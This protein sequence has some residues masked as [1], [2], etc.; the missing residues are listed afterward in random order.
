MKPRTVRKP[1]SNASQ[2]FRSRNAIPDCG[3]TWPDDTRRAP[4][5][6]GWVASRLAGRM[7]WSS[8][9]RSAARTGA[10]RRSPS[11]RSRMAPEADQLPAR[12]EV[13][14]LVG[15]ALGPGH[16]REAGEQAGAHRLGADIG[17]GPT[18][19]VGVERRLALLRAT[20]LVAADRAAVVPGRRPCPSGDPRL[21]VDRPGDLVDDERPAA[22][23]AAGREQVADRDLETRCAARRGGHPLER[24]VEVADVG[25]PEDDLGEHP[26]ERVR[27]DRDR[28]ALPVDGRPRDP[29]ATAEQVGDDIAGSRV[30]FDPR[31]HHRGRRRGRDPVED[32]K[33]EARPGIEGST[34]GH[35]ADA[36]RRAIRLADARPADRTGDRSG[37]ARSIRPSSRR[38]DRCRPSSPTCWRSPTT[39]SSAAGAG[40]RPTSTSST[41]ATAS[42]A[43]T[44][45]WNRRSRRSPTGRGAGGSGAAGRTGD[46][47]TRRRRRSRAGSCRARWP[48]C[49]PPTGTPTRAVA[50]G[51]CGRRSATSSPASARTAGSTRGS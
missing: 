2:G 11:I 25:R 13:E 10:A 31:G 34:S 40:C 12:V 33:R 45:R 7:A 41:S 38:E 28:Q 14:Q 22:G 35:Q 8:A 19:V 43:S 44:S 5:R 4:V 1:S 51:R 20:A 17:R 15:Q 16:D 30:L 21:V 49:P 24:G 26:R 9:R 23:R 48:A 29:A 32:R 47:G 3:R 37:G 36:S 27:L 6:P 42:I 46:P 39:R 50:S 18:Q